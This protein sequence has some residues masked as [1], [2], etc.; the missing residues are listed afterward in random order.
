MKYVYSS[1]IAFVLMTIGLALFKGLGI[2]TETQCLPESPIAEDIV[3]IAMLGACIGLAHAI[4]DE[5]YP[6]SSTN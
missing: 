3:G 1:I 2:I 6:N 5:A 4:A